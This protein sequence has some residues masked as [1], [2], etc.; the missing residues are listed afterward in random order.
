MKEKKTELRK[1]EGGRIHSKLIL[2]YGF[3][4]GPL[5]SAVDKKN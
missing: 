1:R 2:G 4:Y 5:E 3:A